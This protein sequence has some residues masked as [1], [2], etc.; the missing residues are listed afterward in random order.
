MNA[1]F[2]HIGVI[3]GLVLAALIAENAQRVLRSRPSLSLDPPES[4]HAPT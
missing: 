3:G 1:V 4:R 2:E